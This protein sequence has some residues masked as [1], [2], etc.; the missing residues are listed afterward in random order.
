LIVLAVIKQRMQL[1]SSTYRSVIACA[2][3]VHATEGLRAFYISYP[4]TL[5]MNIPLSAVQFSVYETLK[6]IINPSGEYSPGT[7][8]VAGGIAGGVAGALTTPL[9]VAKVSRGLT[10]LNELY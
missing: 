1:Q 3:H 4:T 10:G 2:K 6:G 9:D 5:L 7:H 8:I